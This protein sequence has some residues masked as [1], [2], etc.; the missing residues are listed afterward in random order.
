MIETRG[1]RIVSVS[2]NESTPTGAE[3]L[4]GAVF[5]AFANTHSHAFHRL[6]R[7]VTGEG[8]FWSWR[9]VMYEVASQLDPDSYR[10]IA[11]A[12]FREMVAAGYGTVVE[13]HYLHHQPDGKPYDDPNVMA[14]ALADAAIEAGIKLTLL[15]ACYL[16]GGFGQPPEGVQ[17]RFADADA[18]AW[19]ERASQWRPPLGVVAGAAIHSIRAVDPASASVVAAWSAGRPLHVH[20][21]EQPAE[22]D[23]CLQAYGASPTRVLAEA[24]VLGP[25]TTVVHATHLDQTDVALLA[26]SG[27]S[28][29]ICPTTERWLADGIG[30][31]DALAGAGVPLT[32]GSDSQAVIDPFTEMAALELHQRLVTRTTGTHQEPELVTAGAGNPSAI[33]RPGPVGLVAGARADMVAIRTDSPRTAGVEPSGLIFAATAADVSAVVMGGRY[34]GGR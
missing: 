7:G 34:V 20:L 28:A 5:P 31:T 11:V 25:N 6:L 15:D 22:N 30:P 17:R 18:N 19:A 21:S 26:G 9:D 2:A 8:D 33:G 10:R 12:A 4:E 13:F 29:A 32:I 14:D 27:A 23:A 3:T 1:D 16:S 24:G